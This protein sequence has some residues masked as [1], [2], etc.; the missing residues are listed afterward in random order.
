MRRLLADLSV[1]AGL[2]AVAVLPGLA[3]ESAWVE[4]GLLEGDGWSAKDARLR[5][6][7]KTDARVDADLAVGRIELPARN[8]AIRD[9]HLHCPSA[10]LE[11][12]LL[13]CASGRLGFVSEKLGKRS[14]ALSGQYHLD[15]RRW[16]A[17]VADGDLSFPMLVET[18]RYFDVPLDSLQ[19]TG[20]ARISGK[21]RGEAGRIEKGSL[22]MT[23]DSVTLTDAT[24]AIASEDLGLAL[25]LDFMPLP[26]GWHVEANLSVVSGGLYIDPV[27]VDAATGRLDAK[28]DF[29]WHAN[30]RLRLRSARLD[31]PG[32]VALRAS[33]YLKTAPFSIEH[34]DAVL[35]KGAMPALY[36][37]W[38]QPFLTDTAVGDL[39]TAGQVS[40]RLAMRDARVHDIAVLL[41]ELTA[42]DNEGRFG[43]DAASGDI[44][45]SDGNEAVRS[46]LGWQGGNIYR[47]AMGPADLQVESTGSTLTLADGARLPVLDGALEVESFRMTYGRDAPLDWQVAGFLTPV[48]MSDLT[49]ALGWPEFAGKLSGVIPKVSYAHGNLEVGGVLLV[50]VFDGEIT[51]RN[52]ALQQPFGAVP[53]LQL[54]AAIRDLDL[55][56]LTRTFSFGRIEGRLEGEVNGLKMASWRPVAFDAGFRTPADDDSRRRISQ[57]AVDNIADIG[58]GGVGGALSRGFLRFIKEFPYDKLGI[59][60]RLRHGTCEMGGVEPIADGYYL[61]KGRMLPPRLDVIGYADRVDWDS[62]V[63]QLVAVTRQHDVIVQ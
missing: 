15:S 41:D 22:A 34:L 56:T 4:L 13:N 45:W 25:D 43:V 32:V 19:G 50:R 58:G 11:G 49:L 26:T 55:E 30:N 24:G 31:Q 17:G 35:E 7:L 44:R 57:R 62:L 47:V 8:D 6:I 9:L 52:L 38:L 61:V 14:L 12:R 18:L 16:T 29:E 2:L 53:R 63:A 33:G 21:L 5:I 27:Y 39:R 23:F 46:T 37:T 40:G 20:A 48:S 51:L 10:V 42:H 60:C 54:D 36:M 1:F 59:S 3:I 28:A